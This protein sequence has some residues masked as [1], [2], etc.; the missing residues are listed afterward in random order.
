M[1]FSSKKRGPV[2]KITFVNFRKKIVVEEGFSVD[3]K[4][5]YNVIYEKFLQSDRELLEK[6]L[7]EQPP[8][9]D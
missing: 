5:D 8:G 9:A 6:K 4:N 3:M 1:K 7:Y 2:N